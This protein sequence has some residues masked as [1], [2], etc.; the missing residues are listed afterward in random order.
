MAKQI[1]EFVPQI[2]VKFYYSKKFDILI[3]LGMELT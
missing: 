2:I 3:I 1:N